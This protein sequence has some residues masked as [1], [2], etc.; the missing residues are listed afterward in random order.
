[1]STL[2]RASR[3]LLTGATGLIGGEVLRALLDFGVSEIWTH[4]RLKADAS[5]LERIA[6]RVRRSGAE[7]DGAL[8]VVRG[9]TGDVRRADLGMP[10]HEA[11]SM[12]DS[13]DFVIHCAGETSFTRG[14]ECV[15]SNVVGM[16]NLIDFVRR[17]HRNPLILYVS[18]AA[19]G[20]ALRHTCVTEDG[21]CRPDARH[22][23]EYT[24]SKAVAERLLVDSGLPHVIVRPSIVLSAGLPDSAFARA[25]LW[26][27][28]LLRRFEA[29]PVDPTSRLDIVPVDFVARSI[30]K[31][32]TVPDRRWKCYHVSAG[33]AHTATCRGLSTL[34]DEFYQRRRPL[35]LIAPKYWTPEM[36]RAF[37]RSSFQRTYFAA[38]R[39]YLPFLNMNVV[40]D[41]G[42]LR[43]SLG[44]ESMRIRRV[45]EYLGELLKRISSR[46]AERECTKP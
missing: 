34:L 27:V 14:A 38:L 40:Y 15:E 36:Q 17:C 33:T 7:L 39:H 2:R 20:G 31:L 22:H 35:R 28:P 41:N 18:T 32:L 3:V 19:N 8:R 44:T 43:E 12:C 37:V 30:V 29:I 23:N 26:F 24:R 5:P 1:M 46:D 25:I 11:D 21:G 10:A 6:A 45:E 42:R 9:V 4:V 16:R 13:V